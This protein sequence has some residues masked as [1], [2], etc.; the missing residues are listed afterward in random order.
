MKYIIELPQPIQDI[1][2]ELFYSNMRNYGIDG[3]RHK[4]DFLNSKVSDIESL[5]SYV[6]ELTIE[7]LQLDILELK[8]SL[9]TYLNY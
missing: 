8:D 4:D 9:D 2:L 5:H 7:L 3:S 1:L 6:L